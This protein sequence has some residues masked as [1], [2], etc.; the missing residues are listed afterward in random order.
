MAIILDASV[1]LA[2]L[3]DRDVPAEVTH[4][5][6]ILHT[7]EAQEA[8]VPS[9]WFTEVTNGILMIER[10]GNVPTLT[11]V[12]FTQ[13][14]ETLPI[15]LDH[16][17]PMALQSSLLLLARLYNLTAYDATY[18][19]LAVRTKCQLATFDRKLATA[20]RSAGVHVFGDPQ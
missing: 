4:A 12:R 3:K 11:I 2:W 7:I 5:N 19:E 14:I 8:I 15:N 9:L 13:L 18:L 6:R 17:S 10:Y 16:V 1:A 20:A